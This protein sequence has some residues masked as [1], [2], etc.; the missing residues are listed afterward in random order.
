MACSRRSCV[1]FG[2]LSLVRVSEKVAVRVSP[3]QV[4]NLLER[5]LVPELIVVDLSEL[6]RVVAGRRLALVAL[7]AGPR[8]SEQPPGGL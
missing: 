7:I 6:S 5:S 4:S 8:A 1:G 2:W 3:H